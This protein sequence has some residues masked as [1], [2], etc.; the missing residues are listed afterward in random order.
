V[1]DENF[2]DLKKHKIRLTLIARDKGGRTVRKTTFITRH[3]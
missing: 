2:I 3:C 1:V